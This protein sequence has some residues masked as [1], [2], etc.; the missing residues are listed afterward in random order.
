MNGDIW[1]SFNDKDDDVEYKK[2]EH[3]GEYVDK[4]S[5][6]KVKSKN[7]KVRTI[8]EFINNKIKNYTNQI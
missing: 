7:S 1:I 2:S 5:K 6:F 4:I 8:H 3:G